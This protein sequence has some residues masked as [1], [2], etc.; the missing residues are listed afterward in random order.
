MLDVDFWRLIFAQH[1]KM[2]IN[3]SARHLWLCFRWG[4]IVTY[5][6]VGWAHL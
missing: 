3:N 2:G 4:W 1:V 6:C 5:R